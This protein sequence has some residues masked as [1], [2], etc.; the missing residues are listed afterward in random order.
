MLV[1]T[2]R[3]EEGVVIFDENDNLV[4]RVSAIKTTNGKAQLGFE[5]PRHVKILR[6]ELVERESTVIMDGAANYE[7]G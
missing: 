7:A 4:A 2:R 5:A 6:E 3:N 1:I